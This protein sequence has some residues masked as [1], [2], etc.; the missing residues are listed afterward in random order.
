M[1]AWRVRGVALLL[2][3]VMAVSFGGPVFAATSS[4]PFNW[5]LTMKYRLDGRDMHSNTGTFCQWFHSTS[6]DSHET[7]KHVYIT[8]YRIDNS[9]DE[10]VGITVAFPTDGRQYVYCWRGFSTSYDYWFEYAKKQDELYIS[11]AGN[12]QDH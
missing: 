6:V 5:T 3:V 9:I 11:A 8:L 1:N 12:V 10:K 4:L 7:D 2:G